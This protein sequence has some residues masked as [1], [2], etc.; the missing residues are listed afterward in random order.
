MAKSSNRQVDKVERK[1]RLAIGRRHQELEQ[2]ELRNIN[3]LGWM[4]MDE[5]EEDDCDVEAEVS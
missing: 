2:R 4:E 3:R 5:D 1:A